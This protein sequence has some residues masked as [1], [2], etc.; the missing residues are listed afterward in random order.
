MKTNNLHIF[1][2]AIA[3]KYGQ[4]LSD[5]EKQHA[6]RNHLSGLN[7]VIANLK[8]SANFKEKYRT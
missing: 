5:D 1:T 4:D 6:Q 3:L 2:T 8:L 7:L